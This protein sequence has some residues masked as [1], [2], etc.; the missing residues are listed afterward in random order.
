MSQ[1]IGLFVKL[2]IGQFCIP[3]Y[4]RYII[5][6][7]CNLF[8]KQIYDRLI[9]RISYRC[10][11][12]ANQP[13]DLVGI[14]QARSEWMIISILGVLKSGGAYVPIDP[15]YP[16]ERIA[17][18]EEDT[19]CKVCVDETELSKFKESQARYSKEALTSTAKEDHL[20]YVI[21]TSGSTGRPKGVMIEHKNAYSFV[22]I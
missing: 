5:R 14:K 10:I 20:A 12:E 3:K 17:Y 9:L 13:D 19:Q 11:I 16:Q 15:E 4:Y 1:L 2:P 6:C 8:F 22:K 21:Y 18:M 7:L